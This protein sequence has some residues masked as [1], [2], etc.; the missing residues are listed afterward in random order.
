MSVVDG[1]HHQHSHFGAEIGGFYPRLRAM[2]IDFLTDAL[3][4]WTVMTFKFCKD[5][6]CLVF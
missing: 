5:D 6:M 2:K 1:H 4:L 3:K